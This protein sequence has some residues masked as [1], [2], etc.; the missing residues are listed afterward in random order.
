MSFRL[1]TIKLKPDQLRVLSSANDAL[2]VLCAA[3]QPNL[4]ASDLAGDAT[5]ALESY[6]QLNL[7]RT[8]ALASGMCA[9][10]NKDRFLNCV[11]LARA[12]IETVAAL[13]CVLDDTDTLLAKEDIRGIHERAVKAMFG[14]RNAPDGDA[15]FPAAINV[16]TYMDRLEKAYPGVRSTYESICEFVHPNCDAFG[17]FRDADVEKGELYLGPGNPDNDSW[18]VQHALFGLAFLGIARMC[19]QAY[20]TRFKP[21]VEQLDTKLGPTMDRWPNPPTAT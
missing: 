3:R 6:V 18:L 20:L 1:R 4:R 10:W 7:H 14:K 5:W 16:L 11:V 15:T 21:K 12:L 13:W 19:H 9:E 2:R 8:T 17:V